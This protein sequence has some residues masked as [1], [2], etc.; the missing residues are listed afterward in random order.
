MEPSDQTIVIQGLLERLQAGD[1]SA[2]GELLSVAEAR[3]RVLT[4]SMFNRNDRLRRWEETG[5]VFQNSMVRLNKALQDVKPANVKEFVGLA[6]TQVR[7][8]LIDL[9]R[10]YFGP[11]GRGAMHATKP[12][13]D[14]GL[15]GS[16]SPVDPNPGPETRML[17]VELHEKVDELPEKEKEAFSFHCYQG[18]TLKE[19]STILGVDLSTVKRR[20]RAAKERLH[21]LIHRPDEGAV[22]DAQE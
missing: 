8:E 21:K 16:H 22:G 20:V 1:E 5:D 13:G 18:L 9:A 7:R 2:R 3:L 6:A 12:R 14:D 11:R 4:S 15:A 17:Q 10:H 19:I